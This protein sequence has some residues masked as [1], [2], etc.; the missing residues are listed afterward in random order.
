MC[1]RYANFLAEQDL[2]DAFSVA[3]IADDVRLLPPSWNIAPTGRAVIVRTGSDGKVAELARWGLV[4]SWA[5][6]PSIGVRMF[7]ARAETIAEKPSYRTAFAK[8]R[9]LVPANGYY[10]WTASGGTKT[11]HYIHDATGSPLAFAGLYEVWRDKTAAD[12]DPWLVTCSIVTVA[13]R[14]DMRAI[15]DRQPAMLG[16]DER[17]AWLDPASDRS[18][19]ES[20]LAAPTPELAWHT[21]GAG[22]GNVRNNGPELIGPV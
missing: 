5:K 15:H 8:R 9:C 2:I 1:G 20:A 18:D 6:D 22:V 3:V 17:D 10:E 13:A 4:P 12:D 7:N 16:T 19:L 21:V 11:P 14:D